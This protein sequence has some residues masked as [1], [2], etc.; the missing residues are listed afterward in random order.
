MK[1]DPDVASEVGEE[2][3]PVTPIADLIPQTLPVPACDTLRSGSQV[4]ARV[5]SYVDEPDGILK[6]MVPA[7]KGIKFEDGQ[8]ST[9]SK[10]GPLAQDRT[11]FI[12]SQAGMAI[13]DLFHRIPNLIAREAVEQA[14][15]MK[16][17]DI[18]LGPGF[19]PTADRR[20]THA[21]HYKNWVFSYRIVP[22]QSS[23]GRSIL[24]EFRTDNHDHPIDNSTRRMAKPHS[25]GFAT[26]WLFFL[27]GNLQESQFRY[28]GQQ[29][30][31]EREAYVLAFAQIPADT[32]LNTVIDS[33]YGR[34]STSIQGIAWIDKSTFRIVRMQTDLLSPLPVI[35]LNELRS[36]LD[37]GEV[38][39]PERNLLLWLPRDVDIKWRVAGRAGEEFHTYSNYR[40]FA[41]TSP[42]QRQIWEENQNK[43][44]SVRSARSLR[45]WRGSRGLDGLSDALWPSPRGDR[46]LASASAK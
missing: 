32:R 3:V 31:N 10:D 9:D 43:H 44:Q 16:F 38:K 45:N 30:I 7:L 28:L 6:E 19:G 1:L 13:E 21:P 35:Q 29:E 12:L 42:T 11:A 8:N 23:D 27:P 24:H 36:V 25:V 33:S 39:I 5:P 34:C 4:V 37:Y 18:M 26:T 2:R 14:T 41:G 20:S 40:L 46:L 15:N 17:E 22:N